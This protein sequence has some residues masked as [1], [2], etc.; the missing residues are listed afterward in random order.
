MERPSVRPIQE[1]NPL[2]EQVYQ[3]LK[4]D[5]FSFR[6]FPGDRF[7]ETDIAQYYGVSRTPMRDALFRLLREG[8]LEVGF[9]RGWKVSEIDFAQLDQLYDLRIVLETASLDKL[10]STAPPH[11]HIS[12]LKAVWCVPPE[13]R[14]TDPVAMFT[15]DE[16][17]HRGLV[18]A[19]GNGEMLRVHDEVTERIR[20]VRRLDF[21]KPHRTSA[22]Y[23]EHAKMLRCIDRGKCGEAAMLLR[24]HITQ[25]KLEVRKIT[26]SML[27]QA[28]ER[29]LPFV[30]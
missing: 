24:S 8:Y 12:A 29:K 2:A 7:S 27:A 13:A 14:E 9:R 3:Q 20:I 25:S 10:A 21:L 28:R 26:V 30:G 23:D 1:A 11:P 6:L 19:S 17:F 15:M 18:R 5:I 4:Q 22:T 16:D